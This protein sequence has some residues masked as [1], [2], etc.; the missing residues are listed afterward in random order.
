MSDN[1]TINKIELAV[2]LAHERTR[3][4]MGISDE[5]EMWI[6]EG[7]IGVYTEEAQDVFDEWYDYYLTKIE[8][9]NNG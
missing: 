8:E 5:S 3:I 2:G 4:E 7:G 1:I 6:Y 9:V